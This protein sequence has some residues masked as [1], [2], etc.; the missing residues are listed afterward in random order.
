M[1]NHK[2]TVALETERLILRRFETSDADAMFHNW[3]NDPEVTKY[4][5]WPTHTSPDISRAFISSWIDLYAN[6]NHYSWAIELKELGEPIG[7]IA[8]VK[9]DPETDM[10]HIGYCI[11]RAWWRK[12]YTSEALRCLVRFFFE[13]VGVN[14]IE[15]RHDPRNPNSGKVMQSAGLKYEGT[16]H[17]SDKNNQG[18]FCDAVYYAILA[19][20]YFGK[21]QTIASVIPYEQ[22]YHADMLFCFLAAKDAIGAY[23]P[24]G[25]FRKPELKGDILDIEKYYFERGDVFYLA[26]DGRD[27]VVGMIGTQ[28]VSPTELWLKRLFVKPELKG[29]GIGSKLLAAAEEYAAGKGILTIHTRFANWYHEASAF[30]PS[31]GFTEVEPEDYLRH[32]VKRLF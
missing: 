8:A 11:G 1:M 9:Q 6:D 17:Q 27:R 16:L 25:R 29:K 2:G 20:E 10:V 18:G 3:A 12:G 5:T 7:S 4:L 31:K 30:Y 26:V 15:S 28:T 22:K 13:E 21:T 19:E 14:R 23:A 32:M 24:D